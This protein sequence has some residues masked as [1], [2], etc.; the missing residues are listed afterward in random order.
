[1]KDTVST[2]ENEKRRSR[3][4][5]KRIA[6]PVIVVVAVIVLAG[7]FVLGYAAGHKAGREASSN[8]FKKGLS[9][10]LNPIN[11]ISNSAI[12]PNT[13]VGKVDSV[14]GS[15][16]TV[17]LVNGTT[18]TVIINDKTKLTKS[19]KSIKLSD[20]ASNSNLTV[21]TQKQTSNSSDKDNPLATR[22]IVR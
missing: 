15:K 14:A 4:P 6:L 20:V 5:G 7:T 19:G 16:L 12:A 10:L 17:K 22:V 8:A 13:I 21:F 11:A 3:L 1:M 18:K 9:D 2:Q